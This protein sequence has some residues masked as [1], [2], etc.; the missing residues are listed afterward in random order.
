MNHSCEKVIHLELSLRVL[1]SD[2]HS[3]DA[4]I[5]PSAAWRLVWALGTIKNEKEEILVEGLCSN[6]N[7]AINIVG[8]DIGYNGIGSKTIVPATA[9][10]RVDV[11]PAEGLDAENVCAKLCAHLNSHGFNDI[12][13]KVL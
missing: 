13:V 8:L 1:S 3:A 10:C 7:R 11:F 9:Q 5:I 2:V 4:A 6:G 12:Q